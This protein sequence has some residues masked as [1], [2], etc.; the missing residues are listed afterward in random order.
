VRC[1]L[2]TGNLIYGCIPDP[3]LTDSR[4]KPLTLFFAQTFPL[5]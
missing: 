2:P 4:R 5:S 1:R 3:R